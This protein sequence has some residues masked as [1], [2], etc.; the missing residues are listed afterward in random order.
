MR[1]CLVRAA[2]VMALVPAVAG[3]QSLV[4]TESQVLER[5]S[6]DSPRV[7]A[8]RASA[9]VARADA[10]AAGRWPNPRLTVN[11]ESV[12]GITEYISTLGQVLPVTGKRGLAMSAASAHADAASSRA[13]DQVRRV[14]ADLRLAFIELVAATFRWHEISVATTRVQQLSMVI[15]KREAAGDA[16]GFDK[17]RAERAVLDIEAEYF[18]ANEARANAEANLAAF[19]AGAPPESIAV[20]PPNLAGWS[21]NPP[22]IQGVPLLEE[23]MALAEQRRGDLRALQQDVASAEFAERAAVRGLF[24][25]PEIVAGTKSSTAGAGDI[26]GVVAVHGTIPLFDRAHP[27]RASA[28]ARAAEA[29]ARAE[30]LRAN[31]RAQL[32]ALRRSIIERREHAFQYRAHDATNRDLDRIAEVSYDAGERGIQEVLEV[33]RATTAAR[34]RQ[35]DLDLAVR[36]AEIELEFASGWELQ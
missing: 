2:V 36:Q 8:I 30:A 11:R 35:I 23:L 20:A 28:R 1:T 33:Y 21:P 15:A 27:E 4:L 13:D 6:M 25:E 22:P 18:A 5:L 34:V 32:S 19:F 12:V 9:E 14:R 17:L 16:A 24:P 3:A 7:R 26:G 31:L 29:R 10:L